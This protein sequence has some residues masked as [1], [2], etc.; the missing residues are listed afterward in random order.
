M[1]DK[2]DDGRNFI[3]KIYALPPTVY[4]FDKIMISLQ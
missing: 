1:S 3:L 4:R 2:F